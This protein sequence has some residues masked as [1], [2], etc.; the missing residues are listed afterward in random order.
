MEIEDKW[1]TSFVQFALPFESGRYSQ[2]ITKEWVVTKKP[3]FRFG[4]G[5]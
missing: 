3:L 4:R 2:I 1:E 5:V